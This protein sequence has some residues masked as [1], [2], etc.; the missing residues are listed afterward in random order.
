MH[1]RLAI[2]SQQLLGTAQ[3]PASASSEDQRDMSRTTFH[4]LLAMPEHLQLGGDAQGN[5]LRT[6]AAEIKTNR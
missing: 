2:S 4:T 3:S 1:Q 5:R 6:S